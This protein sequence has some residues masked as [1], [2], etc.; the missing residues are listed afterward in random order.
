ML[1]RLLF[2]VIV[3]MAG[4]P[5]SASAQSSSSSDRLRIRF[6][7]EGQIDCERPRKLR[8]F[9]YS[10]GG[11]ATILPNRKASLD[12]TIAGGSTSDLHFDASLGGAPVAVPGGSAQL[13]VAGNN[14]LRV[15][16]SLPN[17]DLTAE[18]VAT[19]TSCTLAIDNRLKRGEKEYSI[20]SGGQIVYCAKP[21]ITRTTCNIR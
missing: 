4:L 10:G 3:V 14:R 2:C 9:R 20:L 8:N 15:T 18:L 19:G 7:F 11:N 17:H 5:V 13:R 6:S 12:M 21:R 16:W 1:Q